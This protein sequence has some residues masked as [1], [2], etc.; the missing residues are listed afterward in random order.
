MNIYHPL[1][2]NEKGFNDR[3]FASVK[4][5][6]I[7]EKYGNISTIVNMH[8]KRALIEFNDDHVSNFIE[9]EKGFDGR[10]FALVKIQKQ[11]N[12]TTATKK[13]YDT[14]DLT[15]PEFEDLEAMILKK[16]TQQTATS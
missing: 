4:L 8:P 16:M 5:R 7:F 13:Q 11:K 14:I 6:K 9:N 1:L 12:S 3:P 15:K 10:P 2:K